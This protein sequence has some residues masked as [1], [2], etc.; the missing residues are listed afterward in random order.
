MLFGCVSGNGFSWFHIFDKR[1]K[2]NADVF[3]KKL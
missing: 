2:I 3:M 1:E